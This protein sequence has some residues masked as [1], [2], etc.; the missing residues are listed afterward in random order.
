MAIVTP[1]EL[2]SSI[3]GS[4]GSTTFSQ[5]RAGLI[6]KR[7]VLGHKNYTTKQANILK[8][9]CWVA[10]QW[11]NL[12]AVNQNLWNDYADLY[13]QID[14]FGVTK[15]LSGFN[16]FVHVNNLKVVYDNVILES[17]PSR[18]AAEIPPAFTVNNYFDSLSI[19]LDAPINY[20]DN[21]LYI[22]ATL[23][24]QLTKSSN[25]GKF[26]LIDTIENPNF[27][28]LDLTAAYESSFDIVWSNLTNN[29]NFN[30]QVCLYCVNVNSWE[31]SVQICGN[32]KLT[33]APSFNLLAENGDFLITENSDN[34]IQE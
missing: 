13:P 16:W 19:T 1:S 17:P 3:R 4:I 20:V 28:D 27:S 9:Q 24:N 15:N 11:Q 2:F 18:V 26:R 5:S 23:P 22:F 31:N 12:S 6:A 10:S 7:K 21:L 29:S 14:R 30:V 8:V 25:R 32:G 34:L 33:A